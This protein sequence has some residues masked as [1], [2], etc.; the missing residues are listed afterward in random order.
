MARSPCPMASA[1]EL[2]RSRFSWKAGRAH[3]Y[4]HHASVR[5]RAAEPR[6]EAGTGVQRLVGNL[7]HQ[8]PRY[9]QR[10][11]LFARW[12]AC[13]GRQLQGR[14]HPR[15]GKLPAATVWPRLTPAKAAEPRMNT[16]CR[17]RI[18]KRCTPGRK[19]AATSAGFERDGEMVIRADYG[20][21]VRAWD[22]TTGNLLRSV[23]VL[24]VA[25]YSRH[26]PN[27]EW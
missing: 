7:D 22:L 8:D 19:L 1:P 14:H 9:D 10:S 6:S 25:R 15:V 2:P 11:P 21:L 16:S 3:R 23:P 13:D 18:G 26:V 20:G 4:A 12:Q 27:P 17:P 5:D 24:A